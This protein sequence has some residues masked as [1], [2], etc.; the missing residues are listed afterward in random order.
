MQSIWQ[1]GILRTLPDKTCTAEQEKLFRERYKELSAKMEAAMSGDN[2]LT[3]GWKAAG[4]LGNLIAE[5][6]ERFNLVFF[7]DDP[8]DEFPL[9]G[10]TYREM[11]Q[12]KGRR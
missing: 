4:E 1:G 3:D 5:E 9:P 10:E 11:Y 8:R 7:E 12:R 2:Y 6:E